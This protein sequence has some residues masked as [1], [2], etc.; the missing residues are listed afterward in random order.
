MSRLIKAITD[1]MDGSA[2]RGKKSESF[3]RSEFKKLIQQ[4]FA[5]VKRSSTSKYHYIGSPLDSDTEPMN[6]KERGSSKTCVY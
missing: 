1:M 6:K 2:R 3:S 4:E 5:P